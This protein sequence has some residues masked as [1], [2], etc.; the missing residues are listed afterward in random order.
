[1]NY[2][3]LVGNKR[4]VT[5]GILGVLTKIILALTIGVTFI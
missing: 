4:W 3:N 1:M 5:I 2:Q